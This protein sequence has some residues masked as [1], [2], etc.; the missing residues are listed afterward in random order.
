MIVFVSSHVDVEPDGDSVYVVTYWACWVPSGC[1]IVLWELDE[2]P[3]C[4]DD[5]K[6]CLPCG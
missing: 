2:N 1:G 5:V 6:I 3:P 4:F